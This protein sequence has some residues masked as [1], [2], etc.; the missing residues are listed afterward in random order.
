MRKIKLLFLRTL[1][2]KAFKH[3]YA[4]SLV[5]PIQSVPPAATVSYSGVDVTIIFSLKIVSRLNDVK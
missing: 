3:K 2:A 4:S 5:V 1:D